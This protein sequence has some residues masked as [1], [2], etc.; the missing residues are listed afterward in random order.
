MDSIF[1][2]MGGWKI[3]QPT[4]IRQPILTPMVGEGCKALV[5]GLL[6]GE[7]LRHDTPVVAQNLAFLSYLVASGTDYLNRIVQGDRV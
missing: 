7:T 4:P 5:L 3:S 2:E 1:S 6:S